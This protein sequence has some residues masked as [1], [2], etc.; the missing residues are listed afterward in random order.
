MNFKVG[1]SVVATQNYPFNSIKKGEK[2]TVTEVA[3]LQ[4]A[5]AAK[6]QFYNYP[7]QVYVLKDEISLDSTIKLPDFSVST[8]TAMNF[9]KYLPG[10]KVTVRKEPATIKDQTGLDENKT[11]CY[12]VVYDNVWLGSEYV[13]ETDMELVRAKQPWDKVCECGSDS[14]AAYAGHHSVWCPKYTENK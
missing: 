7:N 1:D 5:Y 9:H 11:P 13:P 3:P 14:V 10:D 2:G 6:V 4:G 8:Q 12:W